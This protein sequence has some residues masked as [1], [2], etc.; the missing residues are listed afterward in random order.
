MKDTRISKLA[1]CSMD[2]S[3]FKFFF[4]LCKMQDRT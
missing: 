4:P 1:L 3:F 2:S